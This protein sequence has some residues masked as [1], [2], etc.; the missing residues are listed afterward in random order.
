MDKDKLIDVK[1]RFSVWCAS[2]AARASR[3]CRFTGE[4]GAEI[5]LNSSLLD[6][7]TLDDLPDPL[8][9]DNL[10]KKLRQKI[11]LAA[12]NTIKNKTMQFTHGV[13][14][15]F[16]N[17]Y[18]KAMFLNDVPAER[19]DYENKINALHPPIDRLLL[20]KLA[21]KN[22]GGLRNFWQEKE[23]K[24]WSKFSSDDYEDVIRHIKDVTNGHLWEI[25]EFWPGFNK[26]KKVTN[27]PTL[28]F[29]ETKT[30]NNVP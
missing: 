10:H 8:E 13:A 26:T 19:S 9:F 25:E 4:Q 6:Y 23:N 20:Q 2:T 5:A 11:C 21:E 22:V 17:I 14:A 1:Q 7:Q 29:Y 30:Q 12:E 18:F 16:I 3:N 24:G 15:K 27:N 28:P